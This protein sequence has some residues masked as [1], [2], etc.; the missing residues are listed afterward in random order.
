MQNFQS[1]SELTLTQPLD[2]ISGIFLLFSILIIGY[3]VG[4]KNLFHEDKYINLIIS[5]IFV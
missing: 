4:K 3:Y 1:L 5:N 2:V